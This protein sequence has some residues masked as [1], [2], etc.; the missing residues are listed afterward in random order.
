MNIIG[1]R[2]KLF[3]HQFLLGINPKMFKRGAKLGR[4]KLITHVYENIIQNRRV[5]YQL[6]SF[7]Y[8]EYLLKTNFIIFISSSHY[9]TFMVHV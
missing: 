4:I 7:Y 9:S 1:N 3:S 2:K 5:N 8:I 6:T